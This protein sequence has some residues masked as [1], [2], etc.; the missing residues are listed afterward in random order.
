MIKNRTTI[1][2]LVMITLLCVSIGTASDVS[3]WNGTWHSAQ[4]ELIFVQTDDGKVSGTYLPLS[5][6]TGDPGVIEGTLDED[7]K[8]LSGT[9]TEDGTCFFKLSEDGNAFNGT[10]E[11]VNSQGQKYVADWNASRIMT[12]DVANETGWTGTWRS[13]TETLYLVQNGSVVSGTYE[14]FNPGENDL[15]E[16]GVIEGTLSVDETEFTGTWKEFGGLKYIL[17]EDAMFFN[18]TYGFGTADSMDDS[19]DDSWNGTRIL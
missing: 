13:N 2:I 8:V 5:P 11:S 9:W 14:P 1:G 17:S 18:G 12:D 10:Y 7:E 3:G 16:P 19:K 15:E 4:Y 6:E